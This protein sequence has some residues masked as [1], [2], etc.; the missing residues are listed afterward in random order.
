MMGGRII[1]TSNHYSTTL[2]IIILPIIILPFFTLLTD[3][4]MRLGWCE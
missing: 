4:T 3:S 2:P 1:S